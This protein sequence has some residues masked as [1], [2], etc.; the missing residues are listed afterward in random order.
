M[1][2]AV[3]L[4][5]ALGSA[6]TAPESLKFEVASVKLAEPGARTSF[7]PSPSGSVSITMSIKFLTQMSYGLP[8][9]RVW[10]DRNG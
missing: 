8:E 9:Y 4:V 10:A 6:Q 7:T 2:P 3:L 5:L 1:I